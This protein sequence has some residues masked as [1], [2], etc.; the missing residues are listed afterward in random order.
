MEWAGG[1]VQQLEKEMATHSFLLGLH[2]SSPNPAGRPLCTWLVVLRADSQWFPKI[3][4]PGR[5]TLLFSSAPKC[6]CRADFSPPRD[7]SKACLVL[8]LPQMSV[9]HLASPRLLPCGEGSEISFQCPHT[10][11][12][13][14]CGRGWPSSSVLPESKGRDSLY[15][16]LGPGPIF[17]S[18]IFLDC[19]AGLWPSTSFT[20]TRFSSLYLCSC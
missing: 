10:S 17:T 7:Q 13:E 14:G 4:W 12:D 18:L 3:T 8:E 9:F 2:V 19:A 16:F 20:K 6:G 5:L 11:P 15:S 1:H